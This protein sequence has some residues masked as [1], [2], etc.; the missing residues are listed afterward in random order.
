MWPRSSGVWTAG[1]GPPSCSSS[2]VLRR[3]GVCRPEHVW[4]GACPGRA[5]CARGLLAGRH[6]RAALPR[7]DDDP[8]DRA[9]PIAGR[10]KW[11]GR[12]GAP[13]PRFPSRP[14]TGPFFPLAD[15]VVRFGRWRGP[16]PASTA[17]PSR[18]PGS[19]LP[20]SSAAA[21]VWAAFLSLLSGK[22]RH[23]LGR[24]ALRAFSAA[25]AAIF[26]VLAVKVFLDGLAIA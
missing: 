19:S 23:M 24:S 3:H 9:R 11:S 4:A 21:L 18:P 13:A 16:S 6:G 5:A 15:C 8:R 12:R 20:G 25:S 2:V 17:G 7:G 1:R 22:G 26:V 10:W 14:R